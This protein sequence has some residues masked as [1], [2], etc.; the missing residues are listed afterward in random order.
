MDLGITKL[1]MIRSQ[2]PGSDIHGLVER[3]ANRI[4]RSKQGDP[5]NSS[6]N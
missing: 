4:S 2:G 5:D 1:E 6:F 3:V